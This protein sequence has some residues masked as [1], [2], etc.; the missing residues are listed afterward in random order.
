[1]QPRYKRISVALN[2]IL[3]ITTI[4]LGWA[5][6]NSKSEA[7]RTSEESKRYITV[8]ERCEKSYERLDTSFLSCRVSLMEKDREMDKLRDENRRKQ[9]TINETG[10]DLRRNDNKFNEFK[11]STCKIVEGLDIWQNNNHDCE[12]KLQQLNSSLRRKIVQTKVEAVHDR[13]R[14]NLQLIKLRAK[15]Y[16]KT[17]HNFMFKV[18]MK[19]RKLNKLKQSKAMGR[20]ISDQQSSSSNTPTF[21]SQGDF[22]TDDTLRRARDY[23][24]N[25]G[26]YVRS[27]LNSWDRQITPEFGQD[28]LAFDSITDAAELSADVSGNA[29]PSSI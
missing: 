13:D 17:L 4:G 7:Y 19:S 25:L 22:D 15:Q 20:K 9:D 18:K 21:L 10:E 28:L 1:M 26:D 16:R 6:Y 14:E 29:T 23:L 27:G 2:V 3:T 8:S 24:T 11:A 5:F 12:T